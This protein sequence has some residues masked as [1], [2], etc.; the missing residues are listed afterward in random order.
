LLLIN[1]AAMVKKI[2]LKKKAASA[3][4]KSG[5]KLLFVLAHGAGHAP[6][7]CKHKDVQAWAKAL[8]AHGDVV[9]TL[10][11]GKP[12]NLM[13]NLCATHSSVIDK[14]ANGKAGKVVLVGLGMGA[15]VAVHMMGKTPGDDGKPLPAIPPSVLKVKGMVAINYP[16]LR[17]GSREVRAKPLLAMPKNAPKTFFVAAPK[18]AHMDLSKLTGIAKKMKTKTKLHVLPEGE[19]E[20]PIDM[21]GVV[22]QIAQ[23][24]R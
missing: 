16:L 20:K 4:A 24:M 18:D 10:K 9:D 14:A 1:F 5:G 6:K 23:F 15:R 21:K 11:Y 3:G 12:Y 8:R 19:S 17:V 7:G 13:G 2:A 22:Q